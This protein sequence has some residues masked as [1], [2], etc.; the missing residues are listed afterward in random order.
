MNILL[1][2]AVT[3][4]VGIIVLLYFA[5]NKMIRDNKNLHTVDTDEDLDLPTT[6]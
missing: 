5:V 6:L 2:T 1:A 4:V 3:I